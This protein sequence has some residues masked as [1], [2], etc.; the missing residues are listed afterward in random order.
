MPA[1]L[2]KSYP[3]CI[4]NDFIA[5]DPISCSLC[6]LEQMEYLFISCS[7]ERKL[8]PS[9][10]TSTLFWT[11]YHKILPTPDLYTSDEVKKAITLHPLKDPK[12]MIRVHQYSQEL[13]VSSV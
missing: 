7:V 8:F 5:E 6:V 11:D 1:Y 12:L 4:L 3:K 2:V 9:T 10:Q 13:R